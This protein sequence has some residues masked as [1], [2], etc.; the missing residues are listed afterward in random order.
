MKK[1]ETLEDAMEM[2]SESSIEW[3]EENIHPH[4]PRDKNDS[5]SSYFRKMA[6]FLLTQNI[7][8]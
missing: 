1:I 7:E 5:D 6:L 2:I 4:V 8:K 3:V